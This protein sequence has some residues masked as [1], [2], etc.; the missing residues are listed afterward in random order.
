MVLLFGIEID[1]LL[2]HRPNED[3]RDD[4]DGV[5]ISSFRCFKLLPQCNG[6]GDERFIFVS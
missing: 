4:T 6:K 5:K 3:E 2:V 1:V